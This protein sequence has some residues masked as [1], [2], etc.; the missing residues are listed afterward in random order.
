ME[1]IEIQ[2]SMGGLYG[3][4]WLPKG[5]GRPS[6]AILSHGFG[7]TCEGLT[8]YARYFVERGLAAFIFDFCGGGA[9]SRSD[10]TTLEMSVLTEAADLNAVVDHFLAD[11]RFDKIFLWGGSQGGFVSAYVAAGRPGDVAAL[12]ME[13]PAFVLQDDAR[14]RA[15]SDGRPDSRA[16]R[17]SS[18]RV[19]KYA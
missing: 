13:F 17:R 7:G 11:G 2:G 1:I 12:A 3:E 10:G 6:L 5:A 18:C 9:A 15:G 16:R 8:E 14:A 19:G 4:L